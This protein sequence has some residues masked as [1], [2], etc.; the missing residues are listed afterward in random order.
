MMIAVC[1]RIGL[2]ARMIYVSRSLVLPNVQKTT[3][4]NPIPNIEYLKLV[5]N[6]EKVSW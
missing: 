5:C 3:E 2:H 6:K 4:P 1:T